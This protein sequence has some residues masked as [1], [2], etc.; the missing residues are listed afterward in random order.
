MARLDLRQ[1]RHGPQLFD[2]PV[3]GMPYPVTSSYW[4]T[5]KPHERLAPQKKRQDGLFLVLRVLDLALH[6]VGFWA[7]GVMT[8]M[9]AAQPSTLSC[10]SLSQLSPTS[11]FLGRPRPQYSGRLD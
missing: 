6:P 11:S 3:L 4:I 5:L 9:S 10:S 2:E 7:S 1:A 8:T